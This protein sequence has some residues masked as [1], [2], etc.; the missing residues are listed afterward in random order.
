[1]VRGL[2]HLSYGERLRE[3]WLFSLDKRRLWGD[4]IMAFQYI[5]GFYKKDRE[6]FYQVFSDRIRGNSFKLKGGRFRL[7]IRRTFFTMKVARHWCK[8]PRVVVDAPQWKFSRSGWKGL[9]VPC[10]SERCPC[11]WQGA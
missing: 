10:S 8:L 2:V 1:M 4:L 7:V 9:S 6:T 11:S 5:K 3:I